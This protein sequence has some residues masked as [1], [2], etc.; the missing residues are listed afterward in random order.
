MVHSL[1]VQDDRVVY[2]S[3]FRQRTENGIRQVLQG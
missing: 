2:T 1:F 3:T